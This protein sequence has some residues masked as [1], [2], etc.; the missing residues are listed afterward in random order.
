MNTLKISALI[1]IVL[2]ILSVLAMGL[3]LLALTDVVHVHEPSLFTKWNVLRIC[4]AVFGVFHLSALA[5][6]V[7][8]FRFIKHERR[9]T[10]TGETAEM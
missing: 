10:G 2:G 5:T 1:S 4:I 8:L 7:A 3:A 9:I 6:F